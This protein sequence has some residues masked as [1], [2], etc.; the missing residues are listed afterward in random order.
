MRFV[1]DSCRAQYMISDD[2]VGAKGVK[3]R[4]KKCGYNIVVRPAGAVAPKEDGNGAAAAGA[5]DSTEKESTS[6][7]FGV[8]ASMGTPPEGGLFGGVEDDEIGAVF[9]QVLNSGSHKVP[10]GEA[11][12]LTLEESSDANETVRKLAEAESEPEEDKPAKA[13]HEW[14]VAI[15][16]K[17]VGP[18]SLEKVKDHWDRGEL[19]P[20]SLCWRTGFSD[21][22]PLSE[23]SELAPVLAPRPSKPVIVASEPEE[24]SASVSSGPVESAFSAGSAS[25]AARSEFPAASAEEEPSGWKPSAASV[26]ASLVK[27]ENEALTKPPPRP[28]VEEKPVAAS[29][30]LLDVP[31][32]EPAPA[33]PQ[34][35]SLASE[36]ASP[37]LPPPPGP[38]Y[39]APVAPPV[40]QQPY[41]APA[42][43][44]YAAPAQQPYAA[45]A[46]PYGPPG[47][48]PAYPPPAAAPKPGGKMGM[49][50]GLAAGVLLLGGVG[51]F[52]ATRSPEQAPTPVAQAPAASPKQA[53]VPPMPPPPAAAAQNA[54]GTPSG[55]VAAAAAATPPPAE[56]AKTPEPAKEAEPA[57]TPE[58]AKTE[59][60]V[61]R[62]EPSRSSST[63][64]RSSSRSSSRGSSRDDDDSSSRVS[65]SRSS[66]SSKS[67]SSDVD[68]EFD[69][70]FGTSKSTKKETS[71]S[72]SSGRTA[73]IP[74]AP[75][76]GGN[77]QERLGQSDI[78]QVVLA[79]KTAIVKCVNEQKR[80]DPGLS[81]KLVMRWSIQTNGRTKNVSCQ[82]SEFRNT[83]M[84]SCISGLI[85]GWSFPKHK[86]QGKPID[87]PFTF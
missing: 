73:Y 68:D 60:A 28:A 51:I 12:G 48:Y 69:E 31:P 86:V 71:S 33:A 70:L 44:P 56:P 55:T 39:A 82:T 21:W 42:Q 40:A 26:L 24:S 76:G 19:S 37:Y 85:K 50:I 22:I 66:G 54:E 47:G 81:G 80:K 16:E 20:D 65:A 34:G 87:F 13:T 6:E 8:P 61:A 78:M 57:K 7:G 30:G 79:N 36:P 15:D 49:I 67:G 75:G 3:V 10:A 35:S 46:Q 43:Q 38:A 1:C 63:T 5:A 29:S 32:P 64:R 45:P 9:D 11:D 84:A 17:Q 25:K 77:V 59:Q 23:A 83:Y 62:A 58:P 18:L 52:F 14:F 41:A 53:E 4:C 2:K 27:E 74:P 72:S